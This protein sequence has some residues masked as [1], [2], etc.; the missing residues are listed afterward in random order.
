MLLNDLVLYI[1][2][3]VLCVLKM[4]TVIPGKEVLYLMTGGFDP[5]CLYCPYPS[6]IQWHK[7]CV[8]TSF[9]F[10]DCE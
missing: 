9:I 6:R 4:A 5:C 10:V 8:L 7:L 1:A 3:R 2:S